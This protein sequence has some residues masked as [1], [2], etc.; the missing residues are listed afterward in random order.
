VTARRLL[1][2]DSVSCTPVEGDATAATVV[3][4]YLPP[5]HQCVLGS[6]EE[7]G[8]VM[9]AVR[10]LRRGADTEVTRFTMGGD[11]VSAKAGTW[12]TTPNPAQSRFPIAS[13]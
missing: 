10:L 4:G 13:L 3:R 11:R 5:R 6:A 9:E 1:A 7:T 8:I 12:V 2:R